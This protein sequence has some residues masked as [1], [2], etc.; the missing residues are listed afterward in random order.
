[1][2]GISVSSVLCVYVAVGPPIIVPAAYSTDALDNSVYNPRFQEQAW[3]SVVRTSLRGFGSL[4]TTS[5]SSDR[6]RR[7]SVVSD[8]T[9]EQVHLAL[10]DARPRETYA[11]SVS[12]LTWTDAKS[13]VLWGLSKSELNLMAEGRVTSECTRHAILYRQSVSCLR[14]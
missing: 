7:L 14:S 10:A 6:Y 11:M 4:Q 12:W 1:M 9:P 3:S 13:Q 5:D 2:R 8:A